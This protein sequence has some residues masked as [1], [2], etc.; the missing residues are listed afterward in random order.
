MNTQGSPDIM[1]IIEELDTIYS[2]SG[3]NPKAILFK[4]LYSEKQAGSISWPEFC[5]DAHDCGCLKY[6]LMFFALLLEHNLYTGVYSDVLYA[7]LPTLLDFIRN[8]ANTVAEN[9]LCGDRITGLILFKYKSKSGF[10][11]AYAFYEGSNTYIRNELTEFLLDTRTKRFHVN[12]SVVEA[13][14]DSLGS[15]S[16]TIHDYPGFTDQTFW[17]QINFYK[18]LFTEAP[19][20]LC[21]SITAVCSFY[22]W[23]VTK[24]SEY[25]FFKNAFMMTKTL[26]FSRE[27]IKLIK[28]GY[29]FLTYNPHSEAPDHTRIC[30]ILRNMEHLSTKIGSEAH[31][32]IDISC[33][34]D[35]AYRKAVLRFACSAMTLSELHS[36]GHVTYIANSLAFVLSLKVQDKYPNPDKFCFTTQEAVLL[37]NYC[38]SLDKKLSTRNNRIGTVRRFLQWCGN[39][40]IFQFEPMFFDYLRQFEEPSHTTGDAIPDAD[41]AKLSSFLHEHSCS[42]VNMQLA[43]TVFHLAIQT[44]FRINQICHLAVGCLRPSM[45]EGEYVIHSPSKGS[46]GAK[47][48]YV[49]TTMT[50]RLLSSV[51][52]LTEPYRASCC[53][54]AMKDYIFL[55]PAKRN[56]RIHLFGP[57]AF[58]DCI[59]VACETLGLSRTYNASNLR[60]THMTKSLEH[61]LRNG[62]SDLEMRLLS[63]HRYMDTTKNHY[64]E[65]ELEKMLEATYGITIGAAGVNADEKIVGSIPDCADSPECEVESGCGNCTSPECV[66]STALPCLVCS[67]F[68]TTT[69]HEQFFIRALE[70]TEELIASAGTRHDVE[71]LMTIKNLYGAYLEAIYRRKESDAD[72]TV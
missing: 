26:L 29:H 43:E 57:T 58:R 9:I 59:R 25:P 67:H 19:S 20:D 8:T 49:I 45:K 28:K 66:A 51:F 70:H 46:H 1:S 40:G 2:K 64:I 36:S 6:A 10:C 69:A 13:F 37:R 27:L 60:D 23:I 34:G 72:D 22:R 61:I 12:G 63:K 47:S 17:H 11:F 31:V 62:K 55:Y 35:A 39:S 48:E 33:V 54:E 3:S 16:K 15:F 32:A 68:V 5:K 56:E 4:K 53:N 42:S 44:E 7:L 65:L 21:N 71:D 24:Y 14:E 41:I 52:E 18:S 50:F 30:F 38:G